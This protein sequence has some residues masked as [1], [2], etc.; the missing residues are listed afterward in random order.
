M[1]RNIVLIGCL[2]ACA[3]SCTT[4]SSPPPPPLLP[5]P[6]AHA[7]AT[8]RCANT[9]GDRNGTTLAPREICVT[10]MAAYPEL[11][12]CY[13]QQPT[14]ERLPGFVKIYWQV[15]PTGAVSWASVQHDSFE[16]DYVASCLCETVERL[17]FPHARQSTGASWTFS[18]GPTRS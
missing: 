11:Q 3:A 5:S 8:Q 16:S 12:R 1:N 6:H 2:A 4:A 9:P 7:A 15:D 17:Y 18:F 14:A 10:V 13:D